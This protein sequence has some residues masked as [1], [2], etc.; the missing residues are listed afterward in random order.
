MR[1]A[2]EDCRAALDMDQIDIF[3]LH[4]VRHGTDFRNRA[5]AWACLHDAK[6]KGHIKAAGIST[7]HVDAA[8]E[9]IETPGM[10]ILF[11]LINYL[12]LGIRKGEGS[13]TKEE[14][15]AAIASASAKGIG[16]FAMKAFGGGNLVRGYT[17]ALDYVF[18]LTGVD[19][20]MIGMGSEKDVDEA[21]AYAG[22]RLPQ[23]FRPDASKK[24]MFVDRGDC[25]GCGACK[26]R[27]TSKAIRLD[28]EGIAVIDQQS[29]V[30]C[31][32]CAPVCPTRAL[33]F[34]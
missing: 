30:L 9:A 32:Y 20:V 8:E 24:R 13:G 11:P 7:H 27:C 10:D 12:G 15:A 17:K 4:E 25:E 29:C 6:A 21:V 28:G 18:G 2:I 26:A 34:L 31:G 3:L 14:M 19:S 23:G 22:G 33:L 1:R 16:V 5:G